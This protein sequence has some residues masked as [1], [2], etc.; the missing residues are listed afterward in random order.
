MRVEGDRNLYDRSPL[1]ARFSVNRPVTVTMCLAAFLLVGVAAYFRLPIEFFPSDFTP[2]FLF[3]DI[4]YNHGNASPHE[5]EREIAR[6]LEERLRTVKG[7]KK[8]RTNC[9]PF[10]VSAPI[11]FQPDT[12]MV[13]AYN[14][15]VDRLDRLNSELPEAARDHVRVYKF[16]ADSWGIMWVGVSLDASVSD[17]SEY[18]KLHV[19]PRLERVNGVGRVDLWGVDEMEVKIELD[20]E[21][22]TA[23]GAD[24]VPVVQLL[25]TGDSALSG[26]HVLDGDARLPVRSLARYGGPDEFGDILI[27]TAFGHARLGDVSDV[28]YD[29]PERAWYQRIDGRDAVSI[30]VYKASGANIAGVCE[31]V[32]TALQ[33]IESD[34]HIGKKMAFNVIFNQGEHISDSIRSLEATAL[35]G[36]LFATVV[37]LYFLRSLRMAGIVALSIPLCVVITIAALYIQGWSLNVLT[38]MGL[39]VGVGMVVDNAIVI[40]ENIHRKRGRG[41]RVRHAAIAGAGEVSLAVTVS[42][43]T[44]VVVFLPLILMNG[45]EQLTFFLGRIGVPVVV[46]V[47][48]SLF[49]ALVYIP[50]GVFR[51]GGSETKSDARMVQRAHDQYGR[52]LKWTLGR[53]MDA[54]VIALVLLGSVSIPMHG[55]ARVDSDGS[56]LND[57]RINLRFPGNFSIQDASNAIA[58][59]ERLLETRREKYR[60]ETIRAWFR[61]THGTIHVFLKRT[62]EAWWE[63]AYGP[64]RS[65]LGMPVQRHLARNEV[66][67]DFRRSAPTL[68]GVGVRVLAS[69][70]SGD[71]GDSSVTLELYGRNVDVLADVLREVERRLVKIPTVSGWESDLDRPREE[72]QVVIDSDRAR[73]LGLSAIDVGRGIGFAFQGMLF[74]NHLSFENR[75]IDV[76]LYLG[77]SSDRTLQR[78][79]RLSFPSETG[80]EV[81]LLDFAELR[82]AQGHGIVRRE[83]G[84]TRLQVQVFAREGDLEALYEEIDRA[85]DG[86]EMPRGYT[87]ERGERRTKMQREDRSLYFAVIMAVVCVFLLMGVLFE[88]FLLP[89]SVI[90]SIPF[91]FLG[92]LWILFLT[93]TPMQ[94]S[95]MVGMV[96]LIGVV[97][98]NAIVLVDR[99]NRLR[100]RGLHRTA[101]ILEA[102]ENRFRPIMMTTFTTI[103]G[104]LPLA[105]GS[106]NVL[107]HPYAP[108]GRAIIGGLLFSTFFTLLLVPLFYT[109]LDDLR[110]TSK[111]FAFSA[112]ASVTSGEDSST[113]PAK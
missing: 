101:A 43:L 38:M 66:I 34:P 1:L 77:P 50:Q 21:Y 112:I 15:V 69:R 110:V 25:R 49:V 72:V 94:T 104:L 29:V 53:R 76:R 109:F 8:V 74:P 90:L 84:K 5:A 70:N 87:W 88:S 56:M 93:E 10:G 98:N 48:G 18:L 58:E 78:L 103:G 39:I 11:E 63:A 60:I 51:F 81:P 9:T 20:R 75:E 89:F 22:L 13:L 97:V 14:Q 65:L 82:I 42:T 107:G 40:L 108:M 71:S 62:D 41:L 2:A 3:V 106:S 4:R 16:D 55:L 24:L 46:S 26:G 80:A 30:G 68:E 79:K 96:V 19:R 111:R 61:R 35:W 47:V 7:I 102:G 52:M 17:P 31:R 36:G 67:A 32:V 59:L 45:N 86:L 73:K 83:D 57:Y 85:M 64:V 27:R 44:T 23:L 100:A 92:A 37:L 28:T 12:D 91:A 33:E 6:P 105:L 95:A 54:F 113:D 99:V